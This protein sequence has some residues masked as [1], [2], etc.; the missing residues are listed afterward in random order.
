MNNDY[1]VSELISLLWY[2]YPPVKSAVTI[3]KCQGCESS[4]RGGGLCGT[5]LTSLL[6]QKVERKSG[7]LMATNLHTAIKM[8][9]YA[10]SELP[11]EQSEAMQTLISA[12]WKN[13]KADGNT[14]VHNCP[15]CKVSKAPIPSL[16]GMCSTNQLKPLLPRG[17]AGRIHKAIFSVAN[18]EDVILFVTREKK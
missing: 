16:C 7:L 1:T 2:Q 11:D 14:L 13:A 10:E 3:S 17:V 15:S 6:A 8:L 5:C 12:I 4:A 9:R 18:S